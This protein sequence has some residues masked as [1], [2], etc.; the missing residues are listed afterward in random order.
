MSFH[1]QPEPSRYWSRQQH[2]LVTISDKPRVAVYFPPKM[3]TVD[4]FCFVYF[5]HKNI[6]LFKWYLL[7]STPEIHTSQ[8][9]HRWI[10]RTKAS[11]AKL[12]CFLWPASQRLSK[13]S[14][15]WC[16]ETLS[17]P[18][19]RHSNEHRKLEGLMSHCWLPE[20]WMSPCLWL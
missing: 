6:D 13:Q 17:R 5:H 16:F 19:W 7:H 1:M 18:L 3:V 2:A 14:W 8:T 10:P 20:T 12:W 15:G 9:G 4:I 11:D